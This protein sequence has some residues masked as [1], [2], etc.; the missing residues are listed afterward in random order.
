M[1]YVSLYRRFRPN[2]FDSVVEQTHIVR[3]LKNQIKNNRIGHAYLFTGTR[4][5]GKTSCA[6][7]FA[8]AVNC[9]HPKDGS[10]CNEC[11]VCMAML[12]A[13]NIDIIEMD[14]AS[15][16]GVEEIRQIKENSQYRPTVGRY[17]VYI[18]D[19]VHMLSTSAFNALLKTLE[20]PP[21]FIIFILATTEVQKLP[22][23]IL[24]R[25][26]RFDFRLV[27][28]EGM[29][30][31][32]KNIFDEVNAKYE[33]EALFKI[34][35]SGEGSVRDSLSVA[36]MCLS[37]SD[38]NVTLK[39]VLDVLGA[40][41]FDSLHAL[42]TAVLETDTAKALQILEKLYKEGRNTLHRD[43]SGYFRDLLTVK[44]INSYSGG[45]KEEEKKLKEL[46]KRFDNY[47]ISRALEIICGIETQLRYSTQPRLLLEAAV[48]RAAEMRVDESMEGVLSRMSDLERKLK[49]M[50]AVPIAIA[51]AA[52]LPTAEPKKIKQ[53]TASPEA[54]S[55][56]ST[57][58]ATASDDVPLPDY[59]DSPF[60]DEEEVEIEKPQET[61][62]KKARPGKNIADYLQKNAE[63]EDSAPVFAER[64]ERKYDPKT[65]KAWRGVLRR[66]EEKRQL[67]LCN[68]CRDAE[69]NVY[70]EGM[71]VVG[72]LTDETAYEFVNSS[73]SLAV[74]TECVKSEFGEDYSFRMD[75]AKE[76]A[77]NPEDMRTLERLAG[78][79]LIK[80]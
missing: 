77:F 35:V 52:A 41:D 27:S 18:I 5:T 55:G 26:M 58:K 66:L 72:E 44:N 9:L 68:A 61:A 36:D 13:N 29:V 2:T 14:A 79:K 23:T 3:T 19:E 10:P 63:L 34:A 50:P 40:G 30:G 12:Q 60:Q 37:Y 16:N 42:G 53:A 11:E 31:L 73:T 67:M 38:G 6:K 17:K 57:P 47:R 28:V 1:A 70:L 51:A 43:L 39:S 56:E 75:L 64:E 76:N 65:E 48:V 32:L 21:E 49:E 59:A 80:K 71:V 33:D 62:D 8:R 15:N 45:S 4:G 25:C 78:N 69:E 22:A 24:S 7:I 46:A 74:I 54:K 20:E